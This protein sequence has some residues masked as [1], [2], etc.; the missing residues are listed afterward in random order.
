MTDVMAGDVV[1]KRVIGG[2]IRAF[3]AGVRSAAHGSRTVGGHG[4][5]IARVLIAN[6]ARCLRQG[7]LLGDLQRAA[8]VLSQIEFGAEKD[9]LLLFDFRLGLLFIITALGDFR[10]NV[11]K[12]LVFLLCDNRRDR[13]LPKRCL[14]TMTDQHFS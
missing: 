11:Q 6:D 4:A 12:L 13:F 8:H 5:R 2:I 3:D 7:N 14:V 9:R 10:Q 1:K